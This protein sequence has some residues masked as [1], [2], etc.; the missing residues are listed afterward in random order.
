MRWTPK[1]PDF[2]ADER[3][4]NM[5]RRWDPWFAWYPVKIGKTWVWLETV[6]MRFPKALVGSSGARYKNWVEYRFPNHCDEL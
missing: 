5:M 4:T 6:M 3:W 2:Y 1:E